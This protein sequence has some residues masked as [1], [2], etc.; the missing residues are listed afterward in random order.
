MAEVQEQVLNVDSLQRALTSPHS[1]TI[2][3]R[4]DQPLVR[5][6]PVKSRYDNWIAMTARPSLGVSER[7]EG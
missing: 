5:E 6:R 4:L 3:P 2:Y 7:M 1:C